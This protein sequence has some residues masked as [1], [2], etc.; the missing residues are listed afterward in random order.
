MGI[1]RRRILPI[2]FGRGRNY[3]FNK[4][5]WVFNYPVCSEERKM[6]RR[7]CLRLLHD[8]IAKDK[9]KTISSLL[10]MNEYIERYKLVN[11]TP[12]E[13]NVIDLLNDLKYQHW[14]QY[15]YEHMSDKKLQGLLEK[16]HKE[17]KSQLKL[18]NIIADFS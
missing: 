4:I 14:N 17:K 12:D 18:D 16:I 9:V 13:I 10:P 7:F 8:F 5:E 11:F 6:Y 2:G 1:P 15:Y 3:P